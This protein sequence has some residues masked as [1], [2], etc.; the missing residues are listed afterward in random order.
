[1][2]VLVIGSE[3]LGPVDPRVDSCLFKGWDTM[4]RAFPDLLDE[5]VLVVRKQ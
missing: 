4:R 1:M 2:C 5:V 3:A